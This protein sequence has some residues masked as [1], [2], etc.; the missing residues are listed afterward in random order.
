MNFKIFA[1][2]LPNTWRE[3]EYRFETLK[4]K[5]TGYKF[6]N[7]IKYK[8]MLQNLR[9]IYFTYNVKYLTL[10]IVTAL[11]IINGKDNL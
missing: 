1:S 4:A 2:I 10:V 8:I 11:Y 6:R 3:L 9:I 5:N 7:K